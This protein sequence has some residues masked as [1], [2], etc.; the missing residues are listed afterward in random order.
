MVPVSSTHV[1]IG[2]RQRLS[3]ISR[4]ARA[5][6][7]GTLAGALAGIVAG[8]VGSR[9]A[10]RISAL[11]T[12][13]LCPGMVT[14]N[15]NRCGE[16][17]LGGTL[18]LI[19]FAGAFA[20]IAGG[21][22]YTAIRPWLTRLGRWRGLAFGLLLLAIFGSAIINGENRDFGRFG[23][24]ILNVLLF[25]ALFPLFGILIAPFVEQVERLV[26]GSL[27]WP[28]RP[29][30]IIAYGAMSITGALAALLVHRGIIDL[31]RHY[32]APE[33]FALFPNVIA[34]LF[35]YILIVVPAVHTVFG[36]IPGMRAEPSNRRRKETGYLILGIPIATGLVFTL[37]AIFEIL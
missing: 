12:G 29:Q 27:R 19:L 3:H 35:L 16:I 6:G 32:S 2:F 26:S 7:V 22:V 18:A 30:T 9:I 15:R 13:P 17:T 10:M 1:G 23:P 36:P 25:A 31:I 37:R 20:G 28:P 8:G 11:A 5:V 4:V 21:L 24:P 14:D 34:L 33:E